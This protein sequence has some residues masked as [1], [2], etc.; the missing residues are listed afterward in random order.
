MN[1]VHRL[2]ALSPSAQG[3]VVPP[4]TNQDADVYLTGEMQHVGLLFG[5]SDLVNSHS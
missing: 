3:L 2:F 4:L 5:L 1:H